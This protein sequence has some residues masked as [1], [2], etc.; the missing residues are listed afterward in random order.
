MSGVARRHGE[1]P[2][3]SALVTRTVETASG[4]P[5][6]VFVY[7]TSRYLLNMRGALISELQAAGARIVAIAPHDESVQALNEMGVETHDWRLAGHGMNP[8]GD[9]GSYRQL[10]TLLEGIGPDIVFN[11]TV[12]PLIYGSLAGHRTG[13]GRICSMVTGRGY[14]FDGR[15]AHRRALRAMVMPWY[16][17]A[18]KHNH[19]VFFQNKDDRDLFI[20][21]RLVTPEQA[22]IVEGSGVDIERFAPQPGQAVPGTF[23]LIARLLEEKGIGEYVDAA[24]RLKGRYPFARFQLLGP[25]GSG[26]SAIPREVIDRWHAEGAIEYL[27]ETDDV[28]PFLAE[29]SVFVL[30]SYAEGL[31]RSALEAM[32]MGKPVVTTDAPGCRETVR[33]GQN[34]MLVPVRDVSALA[35]AMERFLVDQ[36]LA[37]SMGNI[38]RELACS[39]FDLHKVNATV[40]RQLME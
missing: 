40:I 28:R 17:K 31:P 21:M 3:S 11:F 27:G 16:R 25:V 4:K 12:K 8:L 37:G 36:N 26:P 13:C 15:R 10:E 1:A 19:R 6:V 32:A 24:R 35:D 23:L 14:V 2:R 22:V 29:C 38:S 30:P 39:R 7:N 34:G 20:S 18:L 9:F 5:T 33:E